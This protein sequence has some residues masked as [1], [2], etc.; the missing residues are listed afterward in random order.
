MIILKHGLRVLGGTDFDIISEE[1][2]STRY[3]TLRKRT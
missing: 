3:F 1:P 2:R